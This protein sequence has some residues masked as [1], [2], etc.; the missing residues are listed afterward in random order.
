MPQFVHERDTGNVSNISCVNWGI[1][2]F[3]YNLGGAHLFLAC[4]GY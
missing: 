4:H 2:L 1:F 3:Y